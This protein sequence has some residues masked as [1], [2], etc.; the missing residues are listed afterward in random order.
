MSGPSDAPMRFAV[1][2]WAPDYGTSR[3]EQLQEASR[4]VDVEVEVRPDRWVPITPDPAV[5]PAGAIT[6]V[7][8]VRRIDARIWIGEPDG[9][10]RPG[11]CATV[12]AGAVRC[13]P[14][15]ATIESVLVERALFSASV[16]ATDLDVGAAGRYLLKPIP[17]ASDEA[18]YLAVH[19]HMMS[20]EERLS[21]DLD[22]PGLV[23]YDGR[24]GP[25]TGPE[26]AGY[27][28]SQHVQYLES[29]D[30]QAVIGALE[31]GQRTPLFHIGGELPNW[32][33]YLRL[34]GPRSH[35]MSGIVRV[36]LPGL[37]DVTDAVERADLLSRTLPRFASE[38]HKDARAPQNLYPIAGLERELRRRLG[39]MRLLDRA[40]R[41]RA[42]AS[43]RPGQ[44]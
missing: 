34:P 35:S 6:F 3:E 32:S 9:F 42:A 16:T 33:W 24:L 20:V 28:K 43:A 5:R 1:D 22:E 36:E 11:V 37:G 31:P 40:L 26:S 12:A 2:T 8:G 10:D 17:L 27:I 19:N 39:D 7:D 30:L 13:V 25:R 14:G 23:V 18:L 44:V 15:R 29:T 4:P 41:Q 38:S 21:D